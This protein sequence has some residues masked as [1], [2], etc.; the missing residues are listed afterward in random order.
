MVAHCLFL[1]Y[2][3]IPIIPVEQVEAVKE[4]VLPEVSKL[5][6]NKPKLMNKSH[7]DQT[8]LS[9]EKKDSQKRKMGLALFAYSLSA[10]TQANKQV[11][12]I[13]FQ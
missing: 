4:V 3:Y 9:P 12:N 2:A 11:S 1:D 13:L 7:R 5:N 8:Q 10:I 6:E